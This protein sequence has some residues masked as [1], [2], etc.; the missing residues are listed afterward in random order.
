[1]PRVAHSL[2][3]DEDESFGSV[4]GLDSQWGIWR[5]SGWEASIGFLAPDPVT[6]TLGSCSWPGWTLHYGGGLAQRWACRTGRRPP[7]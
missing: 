7:H 4:L 5:L 2:S 3:R 1:M 6:H